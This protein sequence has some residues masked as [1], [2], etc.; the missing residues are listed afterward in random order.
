[1]IKINLIP[2][3]YRQETITEA[4]KKEADLIGLVL[5]AV[6]AAILLFFVL[7]VFVV[8][9]PLKNAKKTVASIKDEIK[10]IDKKY[11]FADTS[12]KDEAQMLKQVTIIK[13]L[14]NTVIWAQKLNILS[15]SVPVQVQLTNINLNE[16]TEKGKK[17]VSQKVL[18]NGKYQKVTKEVEVTNKYH[19]LEMQGEVLA[20]GGE[21]YVGQLIDNL[22]ADT[23]F[24]K[25]FEDIQLIS[26][27][28]KGED[29][30][31]FSIRGRLT[32]EFSESI[33]GSEKS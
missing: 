21:N 1:M 29:R 2:D 10:I 26:I 12:D 19:I 30:K 32:K 15:D 20:A 7:Y 17:T 3:E 23:L 24:S 16:R 8:Y 6:F 27:L 11:N 4:K 14:K 25:D 28:S 31:I 18:K 13:R 5:K 33:D 22:K 9:I